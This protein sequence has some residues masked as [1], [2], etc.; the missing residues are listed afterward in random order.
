MREHEYIV[1]I[2]NE[3]LKYYEKTLES[4]REAHP[5]YGGMTNSAVIKMQDDYLST[6]IRIKRGQF[7]YDA[8]SEELCAEYDKALLQQLFYVLTEGDFLI[9]SGYDVAANSF[10][11]QSEL[12]KRFMSPMA[13]LTLTAA[14]LFD[15]GSG[16]ES[17][18]ERGR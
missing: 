10:A 3:F 4:M 11:S 2:E 17:L 12:E 15:G 13:K 8:L 14:G 6:E 16:A 1:K 5:Q 7:S 18:S 9:I